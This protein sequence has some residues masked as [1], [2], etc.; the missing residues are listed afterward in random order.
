[1]PVFFFVGVHFGCHT[2][3]ASFCGF[4]F[5]LYGLFRCV[6][7]SVVWID[8]LGR[9]TVTMVDADWSRRQLTTEDTVSLLFSTDGGELLKISFFCWCENL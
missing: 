8:D 5:F 6:D 2:F 4:I 9:T 3:W 7:C 1:V